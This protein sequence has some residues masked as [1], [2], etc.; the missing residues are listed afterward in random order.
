MP[1]KLRIAFLGAGIMGAPM[2]ANLLRAGFDVAAWNRTASKTGPLVSAGARAVEILERAVHEAQAVHLCLK[3]PPAVEEVLFGRGVLHAMR[4]GQVLVD[5]GTTG[6]ALTRRIAQVCSERGVQFL[7]APISGGMEGARAATLAIMAGGELPVFDRVRPALEAMGKTVRYVGPSGSGQALK[8]ANQLLVIVH[9][10]AAAEAFAFA[11]KA[12][13]E[14]QVFGEIITN[15]WGRGFMLERSL[16]GFL[17]GDHAPGRA[18]LA[19]LLKD[20]RLIADSGS[21]L[22]QPMPLFDA[23]KALLTEAVERGFGDE[24]VTASLKMYLG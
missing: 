7:D 16:P 17:T 14:G 23:A 13:V 4:P 8:L 11:R 22:A 20:G 1:D 5:H 18:S 9:Q 19:G 15:A 6:L 21:E 24:D 10:F 2:A 12:G 3:N